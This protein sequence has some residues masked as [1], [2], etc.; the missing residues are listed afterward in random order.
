MPAPLGAPTQPHRSAP[1][2]D[3]RTAAHIVSPCLP[4][5]SHPGDTRF[6]V[7]PKTPKLRTDQ[8][9]ALLTAPQVA[10]PWVWLGT[11]SSEEEVRLLPFCFLPR[12]EDVG[13]RSAPSPSPAPQHCDRATWIQPGPP[14]C[15]QPHCAP[16]PSTHLPSTRLTLT[17]APRQPHRRPRAPAQRPAIRA[18]C[19][20]RSPA[21][22]AS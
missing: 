13:R 10:A 22:K 16:V 11:S 7:G 14:C 3:T 9:A 12:W 4:G 19:A 2:N 5:T 15:R 8:L 18:R 17:A 1:R 21:P 20:L 6:Q